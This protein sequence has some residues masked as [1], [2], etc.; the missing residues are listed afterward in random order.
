MFSSLVLFSSP[1]ARTFDESKFDGLYGIRSVSIYT[2]KLKTKT[3]KYRIDR[4]DK[5]SSPLSFTGLRCGVRVTLSA[6]HSIDGGASYREPS[7]ERIIVVC[8]GRFRDATGPGNERQ[9]RKKKAW[10]SRLNRFD[11]KDGWMGPMS[12]KC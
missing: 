6:C 5:K 8:G 10:G 2:P 7:D 1:N 3:G 4:G 12:A 11:T 9:E